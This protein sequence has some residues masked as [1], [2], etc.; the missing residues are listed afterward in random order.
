MNDIIIILLLATF[1]GIALCSCMRPR[2]RGCGG[3]CGGC[4]GCGGA[5]NGSCSRCDSCCC[6]EDPEPDD[7]DAEDKP[8]G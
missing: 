8:L 5:E 1:A 2:N 6:H 3:S 4:N 7:D